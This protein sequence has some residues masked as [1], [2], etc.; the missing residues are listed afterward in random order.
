MSTRVWWPSTADP[1]LQPERTTLAWSRTLLALLVA[2]S[3]GLR[4]LPH[5]GPGILALPLLTLLSAA[6]ILATARH[7]HTRSVHG[8]HRD[9]VHAA[10][11]PVTALTLVCLALGVVAVV[12]VLED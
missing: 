8:I 1:G 12:L 4:W 9:A 7:R 10:V 6:V 5:Y 11:G 3:V 2:S